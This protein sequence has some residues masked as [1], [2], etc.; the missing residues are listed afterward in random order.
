MC[1]GKECLLRLSPVDRVAS[2]PS[3][4][5]SDFAARAASVLRLLLSDTLHGIRGGGS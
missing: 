4:A 2:L 1:M 3:I 5:I